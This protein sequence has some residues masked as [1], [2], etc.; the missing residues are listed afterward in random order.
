MKKYCKA[1]IQV[2]FHKDK[3]GE[4]WS[5]LC[6]LCKGVHR[7]LW[8]KVYRLF[9][10]FLVRMRAAMATLWSGPTLSH[11]IKDRS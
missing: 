3:E 4:G 11:L 7:V 2:L 8:T 5:W 1:Q 6:A 9:E 10:S